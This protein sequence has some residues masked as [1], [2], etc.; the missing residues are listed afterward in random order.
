MITG[1]S[2]FSFGHCKKVGIA[3]LDQM[4][5]TSQGPVVCHLAQWRKLG[6]KLLNYFEI[7]LELV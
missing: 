1:R 2:T 7:G 3:T 4:I 5:P 6:K